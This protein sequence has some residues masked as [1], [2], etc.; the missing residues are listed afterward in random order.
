MNLVPGQTL[1]VE[2]LHEGIGIELLDVVHARF[3]PQ[4][5][6]EHQGTYHGWHARGVAY[7]LHARL[8]VGCL[9]RTVVIYI[10]GVLLAT[11]QTPD[12][13]T[14]GGLAVV[15]LAQV[16][17][18]GEYGLEELEGH[19]LHHL[20]ARAISLGSLVFHLIDTAHADVLDD[21]QVGEILLSEGHPEAG[22]LDG[23]EVDDEALYLL[24]VQQVAFLR[25]DVGVVQRLVNLHGFC[26]DV[27]AILVVQSLL[28]N[29]ADVDFGVEVGGKSLVVVA[30]IAVHD[31]EVLYLVEVVLG[32]VGREDARHARVETTSQDGTEAS[33]LETLAVG[34][35]PGVLEVGFILRLVVGR[36]QVVATRLEAGLHDGEVLIG[37]GQVHHE[38]RL[39]AAHQ[40]HELL[41]AVGI[42]LRCG[43]CRSVFL[44]EDIGQCLTLALGTRGNHYLGEHVLVL[45]HLMGGYGGYSTSTD[46]KY[47]SHCCDIVFFLLL[48]VRVGRVKDP[49]NGEAR[50]PAG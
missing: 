47:F 40:R 28:C 8:I 48:I 39:V 30:R 19:N 9:M 14:D 50:T 6:E 36:V 26:L 4:S 34:P 18:V 35:L 31:V 13:A 24:M 46:N 1:L 2:L 17:R 42:H 33:L 49:G 5:L 44:V 43:D 25:T 15:V 27:L 12:A 3:V 20:F 10:V 23:G 45:C 22:T 11:A 21:I 7:A 32:C 41:H 29:L 16:L 38:F 37:Q